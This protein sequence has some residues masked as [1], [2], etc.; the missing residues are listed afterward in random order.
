MTLFRIFASFFLALMTFQ[1]NNKIELIYDMEKHKDSLLVDKFIQ[2]LIEKGEIESATVAG[3]TD[4]YTNC[5]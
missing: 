1:N 2:E 3:P 5:T 4:T